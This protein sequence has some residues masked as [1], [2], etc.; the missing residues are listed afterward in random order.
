MFGPLAM[1]CREP[2]EQHKKRM[3]MQNMSNVGSLGCR[4]LLQI[5]CSG[6][7]SNSR[8]PASVQ[9]FRARIVYSGS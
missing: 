9:S 8:M 6:K 7:T 1:E 5:T 2:F 3:R 4:M